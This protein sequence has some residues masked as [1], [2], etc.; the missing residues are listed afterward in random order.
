MPLEIY[1]FANIFMEKGIRKSSKHSKS[2]PRGHRPISY[3]I[4]LGGETLDNYGVKLKCAGHR[5]G[6]SA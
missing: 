5:I 1:I 4:M 3:S 2:L 6:Q